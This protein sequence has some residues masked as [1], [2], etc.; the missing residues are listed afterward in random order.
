MCI[1]FF[2]LHSRFVGVQI[3]F[4]S[5]PSLMS[6]LVFISFLFTQPCSSSCWVKVE[7]ILDQHVWQNRSGSGYYPTL[8]IGIGVDQMVK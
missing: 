8:L 5:F 2:P 4:F 1:S 6:G 7:P 3:F